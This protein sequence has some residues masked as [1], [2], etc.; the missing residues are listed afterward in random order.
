MIRL[1]LLVSLGIMTA[2]GCQTGDDLTP[3]SPTEL[4]SSFPRQQIT[5]TPSRSPA[6]L[7]PDPTLP[8]GEATAKPLDIDS[9]VTG[10][11]SES[12][13]PWEAGGPGNIP[14][15][16]PELTD[17]SIFRSPD[18]LEP[19]KPFQP[20]PQL[21]DLETPNP[22]NEDSNPV[23]IQES[24]D[25]PSELILPDLYTLPPYDLRQVRDTTTGRTIV[26]FSNAIA[27]LGPGALELRGKM[28]PASEA[29]GVKQRIFISS[30]EEEVSFVEEDVGQFYYHAEHEHWHWDGFSLYEVFSVLPD[31]SFGKLHFTSDKVGYCLRDDGRVEDP[32]DSKP[33][34]FQPDPRR[35]QSCGPSIQGLSVGWSDI[36]A[37]DTPGQWVDVTSLSEGQIYA[38]RSTADP[39]QLIYEVDR[40]NNSAVVYFRLSGTRVEVIETDALIPTLD[41]AGD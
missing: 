20:A 23:D 26:R 29:V 11:P 2:V 41:G 3:T 7:N 10:E 1:I 21:P 38:L 24:E 40:T 19:E 25:A 6:Q 39:Q 28:E 12:P 13:D 30:S 37:H 36:Y 33:E 16:N 31:G 34:R 32:G 8:A 18:R 35:Y 27:N 5:V 22:E 14:K 17:T 4:P 15:P 9:K